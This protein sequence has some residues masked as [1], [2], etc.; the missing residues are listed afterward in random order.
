MAQI[1]HCSGCGVRLAVTAPILPL[2]REILYVIGV[3]LKIK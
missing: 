3:A 2:G 1:P